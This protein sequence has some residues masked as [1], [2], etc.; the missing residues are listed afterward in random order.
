[1][2][3]VNNSIKLLLALSGAFV[4]GWAGGVAYSPRR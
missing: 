1:M 2:K 3:P 4:A